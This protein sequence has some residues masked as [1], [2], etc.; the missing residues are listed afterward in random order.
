MNK[1]ILLYKIILCRHKSKIADD[2]KLIE[3]E[4]YLPGKVCV[5][6]VSTSVLFIV[7]LFLYK[8]KFGDLKSL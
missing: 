6:H 5:F 2:C 3:S 1:G 8:F 4:E 7:L